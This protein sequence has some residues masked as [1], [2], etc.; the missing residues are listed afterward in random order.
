MVHCPECEAT[1]ADESD[2][3][4]VKADS[5]TGIIAASK[6]FYAANCAECGATLGSG[7]AGAKAGGNGGAV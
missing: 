1:L 5:K 3:E 2:V 6:R 7:V 4:F